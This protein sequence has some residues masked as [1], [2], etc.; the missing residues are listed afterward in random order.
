MCEI[1]DDPSVTKYGISAKDVKFIVDKHNKLRRVP[2]ARNMLKMVTINNNF[3]S[4]VLA[5]L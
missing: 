5:I 2:K 3:C 4:S 1:E